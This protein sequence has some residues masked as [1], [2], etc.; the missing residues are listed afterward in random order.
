MTEPILTPNCI[1]IV[2]FD[3]DS[4]SFSY[5]CTHS[6]R[7]WEVQ[8]D[9]S[10]YPPLKKRLVQFRLKDLPFG[11]TTKFAAFQVSATKDFPADSNWTSPEDLHNL[12]ITVVSSSNYPTNKTL[13]WT[14]SWPVT[15]DFSDVTKPLY[16]RLAVV[17]GNDG[18]YWDDPKIHDDGSM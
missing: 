18:P 13:D 12:G 1:I 15:L 4:R 16:Y 3:E 17:V 8:P 11:S 6:S 14:T 2:L 9:G 7:G 5:S 10:I